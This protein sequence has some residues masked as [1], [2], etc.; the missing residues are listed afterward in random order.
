MVNKQ[1]T[2]SEQV[3]EV[4]KGRGPLFPA[5]IVKQIGSDTI[6]IGA[7]LSDLVSRKKVIL[8]KNLRVGNSPIY[9]LEGQ[10]SQLI[11]FFNYLE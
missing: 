6:L 8:T 7:L 11:N 3:L 2:K 1:L 10:E 4:I 9:Y 5:D